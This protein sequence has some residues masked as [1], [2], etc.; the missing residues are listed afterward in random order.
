MRDVAGILA[1]F[2]VRGTPPGVEPEIEIN[3]DTYYLAPAQIARRVPRWLVPA[4][5]FLAGK[6]PHPE[7]IS[8]GDLSVAR[9]TRH[10]GSANSVDPENSKPSKVNGSDELNELITAEVLSEELENEWFE[11]LWETEDEPEALE[12]EL[13]K[14]VEAPKAKQAKRTNGKQPQPVYADDLPDWLRD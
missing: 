5:M 3:G 6:H 13:A 4:E 11:E 2:E 8:L 9:G 1:D 12:P 7:F 10:A 14:E